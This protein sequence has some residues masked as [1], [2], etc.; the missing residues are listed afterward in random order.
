M[1]FLSNQC[2]DCH[3]ARAYSITEIE[4]KLIV[5]LHSANER[6]ERI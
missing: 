5:T 2:V 4:I 1:N 6:R 3:P